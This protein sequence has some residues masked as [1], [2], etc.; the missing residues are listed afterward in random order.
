ML[1]FVVVIAWCIVLGKWLLSRRDRR[2]MNSIS[3]FKKHLTVLG[4][5]TPSGRV[6]G[7]GTS[8]SLGVRSVPA[9]PPISLV[10]AHRPVM[11]I[12][13]ARNR[14]RQVLIALAGLASFTAVLAFV[15]GGPLL[16][17]H[18]V[19]DVVLAGYVGLLVRSQKVAADRRAK[20]VYLPSAAARGYEPVL[21]Q[22]SAN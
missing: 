3:T 20:V 8:R 9:A 4:Q 21:L 14:R 16:V 11:S 1:V 6:Y 7:S 15:G 13:E 5:T 18:L 10:P 12:D 2:S 22:R 17:V 19:T